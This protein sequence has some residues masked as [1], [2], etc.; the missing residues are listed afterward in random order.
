[1]GYE[2]KA[3]LLRASARLSRAKD[4]GER[5]KTLLFIAIGGA[6]GA[7]CRYWL[8]A[9]VQLYLGKS[10]PYGTATVNI[11]GSLLLGLLYGLAAQRSGLNETLRPMLIVG[12]LGAF[13]TFSTF[14]LD[15]LHL[16]EQGEP[17]KAGLNVLSSVVLCLLA[18]W[19]G[20]A[21]GRRL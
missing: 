18:C 13:T 12:F 21:V 2:C 8:S 6:G 10:F 17:G 7:L 9:A 15:T 3:L 1:M 5:M 4:I 16:L 19:G 11:I 20:L 14:S